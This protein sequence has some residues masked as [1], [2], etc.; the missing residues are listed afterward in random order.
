MRGYVAGNPGKVQVVDFPEPQAEA[1]DVILAPAACGICST[2][3][4]QVSKGSTDHRY[5]LGHEVVGKIQAASPDSRWKVGQRVAAV[6]YLPCGACYYCRHDQ[7][8]LCTNLFEIT[9]QPGGLV[10]RIRVPKELAQRGLFPIPDDLP[11]DLAV[12]AE[13]LGCIVKG[14]EDSGVKPGDSV[15]IIGDGPMG[16]MG[17]A[18]ARAY[19]AYPVMV[20]GMLTHRLAVAGEHFADR[21]IDVSRE[22]LHEVVRAQTGGR[23]ADVVLATVSSGEALAIAIEA[24]RPGGVVNAFAGVSEGTGINLDVRKLH[25]QQYHLTGSF[26]VG[27]VH[28]AKALHLL[29]SRRLDGRPLVTARFPFEET[30]DAVAYSANRTGLKAIVQFGV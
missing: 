11:D 21:V 22:D 23:G 10:E 25:Y 19:A 18:V 30:P 8:T 26:G 1:G 16:L 24:V 27:P 9:L 12:L 20:A 2:D 6:P 28:M 3:V 4:K 14:I 17:A 7:P 29:H 5:A 15:L 13:P